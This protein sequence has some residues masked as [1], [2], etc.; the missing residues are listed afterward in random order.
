MSEADRRALK[1]KAGVVRR[2]AKELGMYQGEV[3]T[4]EAKAARLRAEGA[5]P[6]DIK[7]QVGAD[8]A[9]C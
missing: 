3:A 7:Y 6:H 4:E 8:C 1:V 5:D 9:G 2:L